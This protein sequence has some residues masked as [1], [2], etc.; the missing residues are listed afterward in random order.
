MM[1]SWQLFKQL[2]GQCDCSGK[3]FKSDT[4]L[5]QLTTVFISY[6]HSKNNTQAGHKFQVI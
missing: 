3:L 1:Q 4:V 5:Q 2:S 6:Q